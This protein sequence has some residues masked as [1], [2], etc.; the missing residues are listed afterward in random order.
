MA[1]WGTIWSSHSSILTLFLLKGPAPVAQNY[2]FMLWLHRQ[3]GKLSLSWA[4]C[5]SASRN[6]VA[7]VAAPFLP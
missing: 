2:L 3:P 5:R 4:P 7:V 6:T 1:G